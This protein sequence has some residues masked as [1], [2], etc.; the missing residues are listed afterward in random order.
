MEWPVVSMARTPVGPVGR[1][2]TRT[3]ERTLAALQLMDHTGAP[4]PGEL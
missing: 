4:A 1:P 2:I 3:L